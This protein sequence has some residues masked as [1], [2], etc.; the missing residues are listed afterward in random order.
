MKHISAYIASLRT[1]SR[2]YCTLTA[3]GNSW[4]NAQFPVSRKVHES[5]EPLLG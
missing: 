5:E 4:D 1:N 2:D 3:A